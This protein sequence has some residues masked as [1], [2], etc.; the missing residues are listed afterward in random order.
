MARLNN[1]ANDKHADKN[2]LPVSIT[3]KIY[4]PA[5]SGIDKNWARILTEK[6]PGITG[7]FIRQPEPPADFRHPQAKG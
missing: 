6:R 7:I 2:S 3:A 1:T 5:P 4:L